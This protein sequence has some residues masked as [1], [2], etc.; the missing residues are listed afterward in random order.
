MMMNM[1]IEGGESDY[2]WWQW[3]DEEISWRERKKMA[4][5]EKSLRES[6]RMGFEEK[7]WREKK[8]TALAAL[9]VWIRAWAYFF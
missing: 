5:K 8:R 7:S 3:F 2:E 4:S 6:K 9:W 1:N